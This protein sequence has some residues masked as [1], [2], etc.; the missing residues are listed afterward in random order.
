MSNQKACFLL[1]VNIFLYNTYLNGDVL[2]QTSEIKFDT[3]SDGV[4]EAKLSN[5]GLIIGAEQASSSLHIIGNGLIE[6]GTLIVG[7]SNQSNSTIQ[8]SGSIGFGIESVNS[9]TELSGNSII[10][11]D[12]PE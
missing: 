8:I 12:T 9:D 1:L 2:S 10:L 6:N 7:S 11:A 4:E 5:S 3:N